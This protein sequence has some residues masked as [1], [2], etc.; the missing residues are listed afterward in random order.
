M[1]KGTPDLEA[2]RQAPHCVFL[3]T[4]KVVTKQMICLR[5]GVWCRSLLNDYKEACRD[6]VV[7]AREKP[8]KA[9]FYIAL[10][11]SAGVC[12]HLNPTEDSFES[13]FL[14]ASNKLL[15]LSPWVRSGV[16]NEHVQKLAKV[17]NQ[18]RLRYL[19]LV[20]VSVVYETP[21]DRDSMIYEAQCPHLK[22]RWLQFPE[23]I[24]DVGF[25]GKWWVLRS[26]MFDFDINDDEFRHLPQHM[27]TLFPGQLHS[28]ENEQLYLEKFKTVILTERDVQE[29]ELQKSS[30]IH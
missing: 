12:G 5:A 13:S 23:R 4:S 22:P 20:L 16:S 29:A 17:Q 24:L 15:L 18:G 14:E 10:L 27:R 21:F 1:C 9:T 26:K 2:G 8:G 6:I 25:F 28:E 7:G 3:S 30:G 19:S 11:G